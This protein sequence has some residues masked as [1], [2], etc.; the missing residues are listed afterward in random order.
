MLGFGAMSASA[1]DITLGFV[2]HAQGNPFIQQIVDG[3]AGGGQG[4][5][6]DARSRAAGGRRSPEGQLKLAQNFANAGAQ[7]VAT[8]VPGESMA[9]G[10]NELIDAGVADRPVQPSVDRR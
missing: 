2:T 6:R 3:A 10:L 5:R 7:G 1:E 8:S 9:K 4:S